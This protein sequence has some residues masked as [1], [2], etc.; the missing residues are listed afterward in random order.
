[1]YFAPNRIVMNFDRKYFN[2]ILFLPKIFLTKSVYTPLI[3]RTYLLSKLT[4]IYR[5]Q[6]LYATEVWMDHIN[7][8]N[9]GL[10]LGNF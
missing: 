7:P 9:T 10:A 2:Q 8:Q 5:T 4:P 3:A 1:M 6:S